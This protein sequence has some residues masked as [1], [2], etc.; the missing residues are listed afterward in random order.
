M[1]TWHLISK[2]TILIK[3]IPQNIWIKCYVHMAFNFK[4]QNIFLCLVCSRQFGD[5]PMKGHISL[6]IYIATVNYMYMYIVF[7][8]QYHSLANCWIC[9]CIPAPF[10]APP[11]VGV[12]GVPGGVIPVREEREPEFRLS[13]SN[14]LLSV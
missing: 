10:F 14:C 1:Y 7:I 12:L 5:N 3:Y 4:K 11:S 13:I 9:I 8:Y 2:C 6:A